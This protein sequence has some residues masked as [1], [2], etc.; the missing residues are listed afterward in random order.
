MPKT[1]AKRKEVNSKSD[2]EMTSR[3]GRFPRGTAAAELPVVPLVVSLEAALHARVSTPSSIETSTSKLSSPFS[4]ISTAFYAKSSA[5]I[6]KSMSS[7][8]KNKAEYIDLGQDRMFEV[9]QNRRWTP[10]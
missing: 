1:T 8:V 5:C 9:H 10:Y 4:N 2:E 7:V 3:G 6:K